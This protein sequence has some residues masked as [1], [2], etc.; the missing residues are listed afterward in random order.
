VQVKKCRDCGKDKPVSEFSK[1][2]ASEDGLALYCR[3][4][5]SLRNYES[6]RRR[7]E[8]QG[9]ECGPYQRRRVVPQGMKYCP[10]C[11]ETKPL[12]EFGRNRAAS[13]GR[14]YYCKP[15][16][17]TAMAEIKRRKHGSQR[18][19]LLKLR[20]RITAEEVEE[21]RR[22]QGGIC[23][24]CLRREASHVDHNH[25]T[26]LFRGLLCFP[27]NGGLGQ[28]RDIPDDMREAA[29][30][31]EGTG[32]HSATMLVD[33]GV[34][35]I[36]GR[37]RHLVDARGRRLKRVGTKRDDRLWVRYGISEAQYQEVLHAQ[38]GWCAICGAEKAAHVDHDH[39][40]GVFRGILCGGCN[41]GMGQ[42]GDDPVSLR[43]AADYVLG[44]LVREVPD[45]D[46]GTRLSFTFPD[47]DPRTVPGNGWEAY[48]SQ[49]GEHRKL[50]LEIE[51]GMYTQTRL[52]LAVGGPGVCRRHSYTGPRR[53]IFDRIREMVEAKRDMP[54]RVG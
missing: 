49:D 22:A 19:Y 8:R 6:K 23:V 33:F 16:H 34:V 44:D 35:T 4:C 45:T 15:C 14:A 11:Q 53:T 37:A 13:S 31:L 48:R 5:F 21:R 41:T 46:G 18:N 10:H 2:K 40:T 25:M 51:P 38:R 50:F 20:Y 39:L 43:R 1:R 17:N 47:V 32:Y 26:G 9:K 52:R 29:R 54:S 27:C 24:I 12:E 28:F 36:R 3:D 7:L 30:Y 42:L